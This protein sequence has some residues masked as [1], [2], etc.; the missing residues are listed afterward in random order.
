MSVILT[1]FLL[2][3]HS[4][5]LSFFAKTLLFSIIYMN[6]KFPFSIF[7]CFGTENDYSL[8]RIADNKM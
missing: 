5:L 8:L 3:C 4:P 6:P 7:P 1:F 2:F